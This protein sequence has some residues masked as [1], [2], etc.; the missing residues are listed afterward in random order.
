[1]YPWCVSLLSWEGYINSYVV[2]CECLQI[3]INNFRGQRLEVTLSL[4]A[5]SQSSP[6]GSTR[7]NLL[8]KMAIGF[9]SLM[10]PAL[11][12]SSLLFTLLYL[13]LY[14]KKETVNR[15]C[16]VNNC[17]NM[18]KS[19]L[20]ERVLSM[21]EVR[22]S[23]VGSEMYPSK[24]F[25]SVEMVKKWFKMHIRI[26]SVPSNYVFKDFRCIA[27][28]DESFWRIVEKGSFVK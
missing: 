8:Q 18:F 11:L 9:W 28:N 4:A 16:Q 20:I 5:V 7:I 24:T 26:P 23:R 27:T 25:P 19:E 13:L 3:T 2:Q 10:E 6:W 1:M 14:V 15:D 21:L 12:F 17:L 22:V